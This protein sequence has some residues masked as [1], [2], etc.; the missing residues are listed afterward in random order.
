MKKYS[1]IA[2][3]VL[4]LSLAFMGCPEG[5]GGNKNKGGGEEEVLEWKTVWIMSEDADIQALDGNVVEN[6]IK[7]WLIPAGGNTKFVA[8]KNADD[9]VAIE[10]TTVDNWGAGI[11]LRYSQFGFR[12][13]D[14]VTVIGEVIALGTGPDNGNPRVMLNYK[15]GSEDA[16][17]NSTLETGP[18]SWS[19]VELGASH[20]TDIRGGNPAGIRISGKGVGAVVRID[21]I[22]V[23]GNRPTNIRKLA[24]PV[25]SETETGVSWATV[26]GADGYEVYA[27]TTK[28][29]TL[30]SDA[31]SVNLNA[32]DTLTVGTEYSITVVALGVAGTSSNSDASN[33]IM[34][35][36]KLP[37]IDDTYKVP[38]ATE[39]NAFYL[40]L[41]DWK[42][43]SPSGISNVNS[44]VPDGVLDE[45]NITLNFAH[46]NQR[47]SFKLTDAQAALVGQAASLK[48]TVTGTADPDSNNY[49]YFIGDAMATS[50]W[51]AS[52]AV[53][54]GAFST[55]ING[56]K[57]VT[58]GNTNTARKYLILQQQGTAESEVVI[59]S[60]KIEYTI[61]P[62]TLSAIPGVDVPVAGI[63]P[64]T[65][66]DS[67]QYSGT[68]A[69][70]DAAGADAGATFGNSTVY[71]AT[72]TLTA[73][74]GYTLKDV[75]ADF[76]TVAGASATNPAGSGVVTA[77]FPATLGE[78]QKTPITIAA[79]AGLTV[80]APGGTPVTAITPTAQ[81]NGTVEWSGA[82]ND[83]KF[84]F[85][86][87]YTAEV[88]LTALGSFGYDTLAANFF[89]VAGSSSVTFNS[90]TGKITVAFPATAAQGG[91]YGPQGDG[92]YT[93]DPTGFAVWYGTT[94]NGDT[95]TFDGS[96]GGVYY[97]Y[98]DGFN[99]TQYGSLE[100]V[101]TVSNLVDGGN[102]AKNGAAIVVKVINAALGGGYNGTNIKYTTLNSTTPNS[103]LTINDQYNNSGTFADNWHGAT[104]TVGF[105]IAENNNDTDD[106]FDVKFHSITFKP[107]AP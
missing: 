43:E 63:A 88:S 77:V 40:N 48:V 78:G 31:I 5:G 38:T 80:P 107:V 70:K 33:A 54:P 53:G 65:T 91:A 44:T 46:A 52:N 2:A 39:A 76:F 105:A 71:T 3:L 27:D 104:A 23:E 103:T 22:R 73:K 36:H 90:T 74:V 21:E 55:A 87:A 99:I 81:Y 72:I 30:P 6:D 92:S 96:G 79:I 83:G 37:A 15:V 14:K 34:Y 47:V 18:F 68:I 11:D 64:K 60:I 7:P 93:L 101:Y 35:T 17:G 98:P 12:Q 24:A 28:I 97:N 45:D 102:D 32:I 50:S 85:S 19:N 61:D 59:E 57:N 100:I 4:A 51:N 10:F 94:K 95:I 42:T 8:K 62:V 82:L 1:W 13:G 86:T 58:F 67:A 26:T 84:D 41:N 56:E 25:I 89:T 66:V 29:A 106:I 75:T 20:I 9:K 49:R 69:W 16:H